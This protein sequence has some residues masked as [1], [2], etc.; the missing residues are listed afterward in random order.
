LWADWLTPHVFYPIYGWLVICSGPVVGY[1]R[2]HS[3]LPEVP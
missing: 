1:L 2:S 3:W